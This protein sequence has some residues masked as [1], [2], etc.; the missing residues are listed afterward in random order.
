[1]ARSLAGWIDDDDWFEEDLWD[2]ETGIDVPVRGKPQVSR[3]VICY[4]IVSDRRRV[5][6]AEC[7][8]GWGTR[9]QKSVFEAVLPKPHLMMLRRQIAALI[10]PREDCVSILP[11]CAACDSRRFDLGNAAARPEHRD[12]IIV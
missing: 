8:E 2:D 9:V 4:D 10:D 1:M 11:M 3:Y 5:R 12:W 6:V 7:L